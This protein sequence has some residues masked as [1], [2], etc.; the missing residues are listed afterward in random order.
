MLLSRVKCVI[1]NNKPLQCTNSSELENT[2]LSPTGDR[3]LFSIYHPCQQK[4]EVRSGPLRIEL[5]CTSALPAENTGINTKCKHCRRLGA[6]KPQGIERSNSLRRRSRAD[7][8]DM[9]FLKA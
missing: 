7:R 2:N 5:C 8:H 4:P 6:E 3:G 1:S 9:R